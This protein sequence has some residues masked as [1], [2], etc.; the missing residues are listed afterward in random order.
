MNR[1]EH[2][3]R[4][5]DVHKIAVLRANALGD[6]IFILPALEA[7][8]N[9]YPDAEIVLLGKVWHKEFLE[10]RPSPVDRVVVV[11]PC[12]GVGEE[13][14]NN[15]DPDALEQFFSS[16][17]REHFDLAFQL[18][19]GGHYSNPFTLR[20]GART[21][22]GLKT[23]DAVA[24]DRWLPYVYFQPEIIRYL[25]VVA[26]AGASMTT[27]TPHI[28][29]TAQDLDEAS[30]VVPEGKKPLVAL[31]PG[32]G[33]PRRRWPTEK[34]ANV[35]DALA[36]AG[37][38]VVVTGTKDERELV[39]A[40]VD[41]M[42]SRAETQDLSGQLSLG[43]LAALFARCRVVVSNDSGPL[44]LA[45]AVGA[46]TVGIYWCFNIVNASELTRARHYPLVSWQ[47]ICPI[48][49]SDYSR[50]HC[51]HAVSLVGEIPASEV[52]AAAL[53]LFERFA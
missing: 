3:L 53:D 15:T 45:A 51:P 5:P 46:P 43:G 44:H 13:T 40:V 10:R 18:H 23:P 29:V 1:K 48:C 21:T 47:L 30:R 28:V 11:P 33:D 34:F 14:I 25:E 41:G 2:T 8:D 36:A 50:D 42:Q 39:A 17:T 19:G 16:M 27:V 24:L 38:Q 9:A 31:H 6:F 22:I 7:L 20:L 37:A 52:I 49:G 12:E 35:G 26:L 32:A 4:L